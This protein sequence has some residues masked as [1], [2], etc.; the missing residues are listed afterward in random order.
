M[1]EI[2]LF[3]FAHMFNRLWVII[4]I[5]L[6]WVIGYYRY[7]VM[8]TSQGFLALGNEIDDMV[9]LRLGFCFMFYL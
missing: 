9:K 7:D 5:L 1:F 2:P 8:L 4:P 6:A 3:P